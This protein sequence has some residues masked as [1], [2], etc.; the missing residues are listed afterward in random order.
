MSDPLS[1]VANRRLGDTI[2]PTCSSS[3]AVQSDRVWGDLRR[4]RRLQDLR[5]P[6]RPRDRRPGAAPRGTDARRHMPTRW[7]RDPLGGDEFLVL[8]A[9]ATTRTLRIVAERIRAMVERTELIVERCDVPGASIGGTLAAPGD[10][11]ELIVRR[12]DPR[13]VQQQ[14]WRKKSRHA[15]YRRLT[16]GRNRTSAV[17]RGQCASGVIRTVRSGCRHRAGGAGGELR[18]RVSGTMR[19][20]PQEIAVE[21]DQMP[22]SG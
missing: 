1:S 19:I 20:N 10:T 14:G 15:R 11:P 13:A 7:R 6:V 16:T 5:R 8:V 9:D 2:S 4:R 3:I 17:R 12:A 18:H 22:D 21:S